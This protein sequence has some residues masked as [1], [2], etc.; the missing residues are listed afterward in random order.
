MI[1]QVGG[2]RIVGLHRSH[3]DI[4]YVNVIDDRTDSG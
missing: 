2:A 4:V 1:S 3:L